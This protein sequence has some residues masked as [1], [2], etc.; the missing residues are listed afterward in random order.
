MKK[1]YI[2]KL[3]QIDSTSHSPYFKMLEGGYNKAIR[4]FDCLFFLGWL[5]VESFGYGLLPHNQGGHIKDR[6]LDTFFHAL[7]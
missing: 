6:I 1:L 2:C 4:R 7:Q 3:H 5:Y